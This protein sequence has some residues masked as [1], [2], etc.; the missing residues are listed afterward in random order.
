M[1]SGFSFSDILLL[2][3]K[4]LDPYALASYLQDTATAFHKF[5]DC[6]RII[7]PLNQELSSQR[8]TLCHAARVVIGNGLRILG[9]SA[10]EK[11]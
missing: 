10:P 3:H 9:V 5:Y 8:L 11:M 7:D 1:S 2:C 4:E 6:H